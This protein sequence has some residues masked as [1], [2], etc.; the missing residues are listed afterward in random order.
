MATLPTF[1]QLRYLSALGDTLNFTKAAAL[2]FVGQST[3][4]AGLKELEDALGIQ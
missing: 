2:C 1:K 4:S 3:L